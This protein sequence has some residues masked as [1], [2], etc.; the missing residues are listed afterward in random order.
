M[1][2]SSSFITGLALAVSLAG[3]VTTAATAKSAVD[4]PAVVSAK[5][6][7]SLL[8]DLSKAG[9]RLVAV[10]DRG[11]ILFSDDQGKTWAQAKVP[12]SVMLT[13]V[14]FP[15]AQEGWAVGHNG[16]ILHSS[17]AGASWQLQRADRDSA[18]EKAGAP[19]LGV[20]FAD[21]QNG[22]AVGAYGYFLATHDGG[23]TW[24]NNAS[25]LKN[26]DGWHLN[27]IRGMSGTTTV[28]IV[29]EHGVLFRSM[30]KGVTWSALASP[31]DGSFFG[32]API[33]PDLV[34]IFG[35]QGRLFASS[36]LG[37]Q[38]HQV[39]TGVTSGLNAATL[40]EDGRVIV[41]GNAGVVLAAK[42]RSLNLIPETRSDR[43][44]I[45]A[46]LPLAGN[47]LLTAGDG[48][49]KSLQAASK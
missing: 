45:T 8:I 7:R 39:Q 2:I 42:D 5:A 4:R 25:A 14:H 17:D 20:W 48:G 46:I 15:N 44:S 37:V 33:A 41:V 6:S 34:L 40:L 36:D 22:Y 12:V 32:V 21:N 18:S 16:V 30:D 27:A 23:K 49:V 10:G 3:S 47:G 28:F 1:K 9:S 38:W 29:G 31:F 19:L 43:Q 24:S 11:H 13:S 26:T 35:L